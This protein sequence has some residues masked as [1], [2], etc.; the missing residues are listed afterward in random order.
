MAVNVRGVSS[1]MNLDYALSR[2]THTF[3]HTLMNTYWY[4]AMRKDGGS[5]I[6]TDDENMERIFSEKDKAVTMAEKLRNDIL[7]E[8]DNL[9]SNALRMELARFFTDF[10]DITE[11]LAVSRKRL[12]IMMK[13][14]KEKKVSFKWMKMLD[15]LIEREKIIQARSGLVS[16]IYNGSF[17]GLF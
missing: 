12:W 3:A 2:P 1:V 7:T 11:Y 8:A 9:K 4:K 10:A 13:F 17:D 15:G 5:L 16:G 14:Q 6:A